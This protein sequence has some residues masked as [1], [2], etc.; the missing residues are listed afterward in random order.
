MKRIGVVL[1]QTKPEAA[2]TAARVTAALA[3]KGVEVRAA[4]ADAARIGHEV[5]AVDR[6]AQDVDLVVAFGGD[7]TLLRAAEAVRGTQIPV[8]GVNLGHLGFL[9]G[10]E[11]AELDDAIGRLVDD[12]V[13]V[14]ERMLL[15]A[16]VA[17]SG[18]RIWALNDIIV[19]KDD[20]GR[21]IRFEVR[22]GGERVTS[23]AAD[24]VIVATSTGSTAYSFSAGGPVIS[25]RIDCLVITP[26]APHGL[27]G[28]TMVAA[29]DEGVEVLVE[30][31][32]DGVAVSADG[33]P[34]GRFPDGGTLAARAAEGRIHLARPEATSFWRLVREKFGVPGGQD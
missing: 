12:G 6:F 32:P 7:G 2:A 1:H 33:G 21:S 15:E 5:E 18:E 31:G 23:W 9:S 3:E 26:V 34:A 22:I 16:T 17:P 29:P 24:G 19:A 20:V 4:A 25:P 30:P 10:L 27:F 11:E 14:E 13:S 8:L 28:R